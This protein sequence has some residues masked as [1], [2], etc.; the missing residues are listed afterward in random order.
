MGRSHLLSAARSLVLLACFACDSKPD[1]APAP[2]ASG[3][4]PSTAAATATTRAFVVDPAST[5]TIDMPGKDEHIKARTSAAKGTFT[6]EPGA[7][8]NSRGEVR[9]DL[10]SL[11]TN[12]FEDAKKNADQTTH[13]RTWLE[14][15]VE[16][17]VKEEHRYA[18]L[19][20]RS[21]DVAGTSDLSKVPLNA[22]TR[23]VKAVVHGDVLVHGHKVERAIP[24]VL[25]FA[26]ANG[27]AAVA[28][29][30]LRI[31]TEKPLNIVLKE[32][33]VMPRD[34]VGKVLIWTSELA[35]RVATDANVDVDL[36]AAAK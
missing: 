25:D 26:Y 19:A 33:E 7:L 4:A 28:S 29:N 3:L 27:G 24:V 8:Q 11:T 34:P 12:T 35:S 14:A 10:A 36:K 13:A 23:Q 5:T 15:V 9:I 30:A 21:L 1:V 31:R 6:I 17:A 22:G 18:V 2:A 32:H 20:V 16:G